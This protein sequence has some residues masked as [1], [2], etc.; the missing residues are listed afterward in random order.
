MD[1]L[2]EILDRVRNHSANSCRNAETPES[3]KG[4]DV[5]PICNGDEWILVEKDGVGEETASVT[6]GI[7][8]P[9]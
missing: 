8:V 4:S 1:Q 2:E 5:C 3:S 7:L 6:D 9:K